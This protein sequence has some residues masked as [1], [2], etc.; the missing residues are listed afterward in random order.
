MRR[1]AC[2]T[3]IGASSPPR[4]VSF[5]RCQ[6]RYRRSPHAAQSPLPADHAGRRPLAQPRH[7][8]RRR[9]RRWRFREADR[10]RGQRPQHDESVQRRHPAAR[11]PRDGGARGSRRDAAG[12]RRADSDRRH[13]HGHRRHEVFARVARS[14]RRR[15]RDRRSTASAWTA[16]SSS[17]AATRTCRAA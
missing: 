3:T 2:I 13:R 15:D 9:L 7:A 11:R 5:V 10:R 8:A 12:V 1:V 6:S 14:D 17:A 4:P 16:C